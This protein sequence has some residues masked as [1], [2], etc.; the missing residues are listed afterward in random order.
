V[1]RTG[2]ALPCSCACCYGRFLELEE[3]APVRI[4]NYIGNQLELSPVLFVDGVRRAATETEYAE[5]I[6]RYLGYVRLHREVQR[7]LAEWVTERTLQGLSVEEVTQ[8]AERWLRGRCVVLPR[9]RRQFLRS[10]SKT[11]DG[12]L[13]DFARSLHDPSIR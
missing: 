9:R 13:P 7:E 2:A 11:G 3:T 6:R 8:Q 12:L 5:R 4:V 1:K 10:T